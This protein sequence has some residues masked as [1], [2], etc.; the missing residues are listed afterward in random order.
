MDA[1]KLKLYMQLVAHL[2]L[3]ARVTILRMLQMS[4]L[5]KYMDLKT[6]LTVS[7]IRSFLSPSKP[8]SISE[9]QRLLNRDPGVKGRI[10]VANY[11]APA[12]KETS[13]RDVVIRAI[14]NLNLRQP[15]N[16][17]GSTPSLPLGNTQCWPDVVPVEAEWVGYRAGATPQ[18]RLPPDLTEAE[19][20]AEMMK[21]VKGKTTILHLHGGAYF[22]MDPSTYRPSTKLLA[23]LTGG[24]CYSVRYRLAPQNPFPAALIDALLSYLNLLYPPLGA[25]H[26]AVKPEHVVFSGDS[27]GGNLCM[28]LTQ[29]LL[30]F[31][32]TDTK[33]QWFGQEVSVPLPAGVALSSPWL[34]L[35]HSSPS[36]RTNAE[37]DYLPM[38]QGLD[39]TQR[40]SCPAWP[41]DP[42]RKMLYCADALVTHPLV[43]LLAADSWEGCP[44]VYMSCGWE[45]LADEDKYL[46][47]KLYSDGVQ[48]V[49][50]EFEA[51]PHCFQ[52]VLMG[53][54][55]SV[56]SFDAWAGFIR[57]VAE[58]GP[59][60]SVFRTIE[61]KTLN[62]VAIDPSGLSP[63][64]EEELRERLRVFAREEPPASAAGDVGMKL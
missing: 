9:T 21:E 16:D 5:S 20:Y 25:F 14:E 46:A 60:K 52:A 24:R 34:D 32:R 3:L 18:S 51:M 39:E 59:V 2:P 42:P 8:L 31:K 23:N 64:T 22:L 35:T 37:F 4:P 61:A 17:Q 30:E 57:D 41:A 43:T 11:T 6:E 1:D 53:T 26:E 40:P 33:I 45:L 58:K 29:L 27:A 50:E 48:V 55:V 19:K 10:W 38:L 44:P 62:E 15:G 56:R 47:R 13:I 36:C 49:F 54:P 7:L 63:Y 12:P 28:A